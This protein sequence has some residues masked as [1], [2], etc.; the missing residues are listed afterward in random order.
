M[1]TTKSGMTE[2]GSGMTRPKAVDIR[3][4]GTF[5]ES[6]AAAR[7]ATA[8]SDV[9]HNLFHL[10]QRMSKELLEARTQVIEPR[11][12]VIRVQ[13]AVLGALAPAVAQV[14]A[15]AALAGQGF[16]LG[17]AELDLIP[18]QGRITQLT[19]ANVANAVLGINVVIARIDTAVVLDGQ[20]LAADFAVH[21]HL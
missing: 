14:G 7:L 3:V 5:A 17:V 13:N 21:T 20:R 18:L 1:T 6:P 4:P 11:L 19:D 16:V 8:D 2:T 12:T 10:W 9:R 15:L